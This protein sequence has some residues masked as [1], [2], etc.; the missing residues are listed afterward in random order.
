METTMQRLL[1]PLF[2]LTLLLPIVVIDNPYTFAQVQ[3]VP[4]NPT[5]NPALDPVETAHDHFHEKRYAEA[6]KAYEDLLEKGIPKANNTYIPLRQS[7]KDSI[8]LML[9]QSYVKVGED[10]AAQR[11]FKEIINENPNGSYSTQAVH[12]LGNLHWQ[13][14]QFREAVLQ[15]KQILNGHPNTTAAA[16]VLLSG[17]TSIQRARPRKRWKVISTSSIIILV[18]RIAQVR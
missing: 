17:N 3:T 5:A 4:I 1:T 8:R 9:G 10:P 2:I 13:R 18:P 15:C 11:V 7:Q 14:Y 6:I 12:R 16:T